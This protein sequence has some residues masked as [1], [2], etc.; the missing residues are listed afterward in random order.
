MQYKNYTDDA[1]YE[2]ERQRTMDYANAYDDELV[3]ENG[4]SNRVLYNAEGRILCEDCLIDEVR[5]TFMQ[6]LDSEDEEN[7]S[8]SIIR[9]IVSD[10][11]D[12]EIL[13]YI[14]NRYEKV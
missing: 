9:D 14:E 8:F 1:L 13:T 7:I 11:S 5:K 12:S 6:L 2:L 4:C 10:F 3:C